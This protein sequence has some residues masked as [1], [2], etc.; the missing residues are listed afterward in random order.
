MPTRTR[1]TSSTLRTRGP[2]LGLLTA[3][4]TLLGLGIVAVPASAHDTLLSST[5]AAD[6]T[7]QTAPERVVLTFSGPIAELGNEVVVTDPDGVDVHDGDP[8]ASGA[9]LTVALVNDL[10][11]GTYTVTWRAVSS[12]GHPISGDFT[13]DLD[14]PDS[15]ADAGPAEPQ[16]DSNDPDAD[17]TTYVTLSPED[18]PTAT[19]SENDGG[20]PNWVWAIV[21]AVIVVIAALIVFWVRRSS[22]PREDTHDG[23]PGRSGGP[24]A[25]SRK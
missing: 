11:S 21:A 13:F 22:R 4:L 20:V 17:A 15:P 2:V 9:D 25:P 24:Q 7:S 1:S 18:E 8:Q 19:V 3:L 16:P 12:D 23:G 10:P 14:L 5:P 6:S